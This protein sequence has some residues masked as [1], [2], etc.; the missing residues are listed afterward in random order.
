MSALL[1]PGDRRDRIILRNFTKLLYVLITGRPNVNSA[2]KTHGKDVRARPVY[3]VQ[4]EV[5][6][7]E[8]GVQ[9]FERLFGNFTHAFELRLVICHL[10]VFISAQK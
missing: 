3:K 6:L 2:V 8:W 4:V 5:I 1:G 10:Y 9:N 7:K